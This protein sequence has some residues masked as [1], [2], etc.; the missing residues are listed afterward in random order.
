MRV[1]VACA[2]CKRQ[3]DASSRSAGSR[4]HCYCGATLTVP[5]ARSHEATVVRCSACGA[6]RQEG[7]EACG[8]CGS[9]FTLHERDLHTI[10]P[11]CMAR[12]SDRARY[13]HHCAVPLV[14]QPLGPLTRKSCPACGDGTQ[15]TSR[16]LGEDPV[17]ILECQRCTGI[18]LAR[19]AFGFVL[20]LARRDARAEDERASAPRPAPLRPQEGPLY[21]PCPECGVLM[22]RFNYGRRSGIIV[23]SC[24]AHGLWFDP[25]ELDELLIWVRRGGEAAAARR[26]GEEEAQLQRQ[27]SLHEQHRRHSGLPDQEAGRSHWL[28]E[29]LADILTGF[30][31]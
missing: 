25:S 26:Y 20:D 28:L 4:F 19:E 18:W 22:H 5:E 29:V 7:A 17:P 12:V 8:F 27:R 10:C 1:L 9:D 21:R 23:D 13:C 31:G 6:P 11:S 3:F 14:P 15:L 2:D 30:I 16:G 24:A